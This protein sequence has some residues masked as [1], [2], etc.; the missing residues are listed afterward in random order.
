MY[1]QFFSA[2]YDYKLLSQN[3]CVKLHTWVALPSLYTHNA[4]WI[5][6]SP[7]GLTGQAHALQFPCLTALEPAWGWMGVGRGVFSRHLQY[8]LK[9][10]LVFQK[11]WNCWKSWRSVGR[12]LASG[13]FQPLEVILDKLHRYLRVTQLPREDSELRPRIKEET[14]SWCFEVII[15][16]ACCW[17]YSRC[18]RSKKPIFG[19]T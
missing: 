8:L 18:N 15:S 10:F 1:L 12:V 7:G 2:P 11:Y 3:L 5:L 13:I 16:G 19:A 4:Q 6:K 17:S 9:G 14:V